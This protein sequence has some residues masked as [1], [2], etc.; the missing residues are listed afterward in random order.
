MT[1]DVH[2]LNADQARG[3]EPDENAWM[4]ASAGTGKTEVLTA[5]ILRLL[6]AGTRPESILAITFTKAGAAEMARRIRADLAA[7]VQLDDAALKKQLWRIHTPQHLDAKMLALARTL[8]ARVIDAP[9]GGLA[10][11]TIH[12]FCQSLLA[13][14]PE[15]AGL[16]PGFRPLEEREGAMLQ[17]DLLSELIEQAPRSGNLPFLAR[18]DSMALSM[19]EGAATDYLYACARAAP[20]LDALPA[21][22]SPWLRDQFGLP[23]DS[24]TA[25]WQLAHCRISSAQEDMLHTIITA[26]VGWGTATGVTAASQLSDWLA[27]PVEQR[28]TTVDAAL[29]C[30]TTA[31]DAL[32]AQYVNPKQCGD[33]QEIAERVAG[34]LRDLRDVPMQMTAC[35]QAADG[36]EAGRVFS[37]AY[38][39][40]KRRDGVVDFDDLIERT[41]LMLSSDGQA[42]WIKYKLDARIDHI[43]VDEAQDTN[44]AQWGI[45]KRLTEEYFAGAGAKDDAVRTLFVVGDAKQAIYGFQGTSPQFFTAAASE[46]AKVGHAAERPFQDLSIDTNFRSS[47]AILTVVD[48]LVEQV[49]AVNLGLDDTAVRHRPAVTGAAGRVVMWPLE[50]PISGDGDR[51]SDPDDVDDAE[52]GAARNDEGWI[53][54]ATRRIAGK[55]A[56]TVRDWVDHGI[57]GEAV[58]PGD[59]MILVRKRTDLAALIV[60]RLQGQ[61]IPVAGVDR[62]K[63]QAPIAVQDLVAAARFALQPLDSLNLASLLVSPLV[64][65]THDELVDH[66]WRLDENGRQTMALWPHLN[67]RED[68]KP[69]LEPLYEML[70]LI[71]YVSPSRFFETIL[72]GPIQGRAKLLARLGNAA[73]DPIEEL[74]SQ[75]LG[76]ETRE[77]NSMHG[78]LQWFDGGKLEIKRELEST[79]GVARVMTVH[80]AKGLQGRIV[81]LADAAVNPY[82]RRDTILQWAT[83]EGDIP[84]PAIKKSQQTPPYANMV[85]ERRMEAM[86]EHWRLLYVA[87]TRAERMLFVCGASPARGELPQDSWYGA[88]ESAAASHGG[89]WRENNGSIWGSDLSYLEAGAT[90][91]AIAQSQSD[92]VTRFPLPHWILQDPTVESI[93]PRPLAPSSDEA[94]AELSV[95]APPEPAPKELRE[96]AISR[97]ILIHSLFERLPGVP[98]KDRH[99]SASRWLLARAPQMTSTEH[100]AMTDAV[101]AVL[102]D[103]N[104]AHI[105]G[106]GSLAEVPFSALVEGRVIAGTIDRLL[107]DEEAVHIVDF[108]SGRYLPET[109]EQVPQGYLKQ[110]AAY[111]AAMQ[112]IFPDRTVVA[113]LLFSA[114][115]KQILLPDELLHRHKPGLGQR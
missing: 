84:I 5:R 61:G 43:L 66:G 25:A 28:A 55:I 24:G 99:D 79:A 10:I 38:A 107:V 51:E 98:P 42:E 33:V 30:I 48:T 87:M 114:G 80:G 72:S 89:Q 23:R 44:A 29:L 3:A 16:A 58:V 112:V 105:F 14:F 74:L 39:D 71:G 11:Q 47:S 26:N 65:W 17:R 85:A 81:I 60:S 15:E 103:A 100:S 70:R 93:P 69:R 102:E 13:S 8:F 19:G 82:G 88:L 45:I 67:R 56:R 54:T 68:L 63:L 97:G 35:D 78:F 86:R 41:L 115:P 59:V 109:A 4:S 40:R 73:R 75:A 50:P 106:P 52:V 92:G 1:A 94:L 53:D 2:R 7:W 32:R 37:R 77:G 95:A 34:F 31:K 36:L 57:D 49:G 27:G 12:S 22:I 96:L 9:G 83:D 64:G 18:L 62:L 91:G 6:L 20:A 101:I 76:Y 90:R 46:F 113:S 108:K 111:V 110:M 104:F 21:G